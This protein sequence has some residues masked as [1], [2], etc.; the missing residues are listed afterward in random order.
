[1]RP[2]LKNAFFD[3]LAHYWKQGCSVL[4]FLVFTMGSGY[5]QTLSIADVNGNEDDG[6]ITVSVTLDVEV[7]GGFTVEVSTADGTATLADN[8]YASIASQTLAFVGTAG[9]TQTFQV[10]PI[11]DSKVEGDETL[12]ISMAN[13]SVD[14]DVTAT[15][16]VTILNDDDPGFSI[17][18]TEGSTQTSENG[19]TDSFTVV[20]DNGPETAVIID[21][22]SGDVGEGTVAPAQLTF[23]PL[24]YN[25]PRTVTVSGVDDTLLDGP[26]TYDITVSVGATSNSQFTGLDPQN[27][28][29]EN[30]D[31][32][33]ASATISSA[34]PVAAELGLV[35]ASFTIALDMV[36]NTGSNFVVG[37]T[38]DGTAI[39]GTDYLALDGTAE[40]PNGQQEVTILVTPVNDDLTEDIEEVV[41]TLSPGPG[42]TIGSP[43]TVT[44]TIGSEDDV[45]P[46]GYGITITEDL[47]DSNNQGNIGYTITGIPFLTSYE[48]TISSSE[49]GTPIVVNGSTFL[50]STL[51]LSED[52]SSLPDGIITFTVVLTNILGTEG[53]PESAL[54]V[55]NTVA[56]SGY[57]VS[58]N[59]DPIHSGNMSLVG[60][61]ISNAE[62]GANY[63]YTFSDGGGTDVSNS[64]QITLASQQITGIDLSG[65][66]DGTIT[67]SVFLSNAN[68]NGPVETDTSLKGSCFAG[69]TA[70]DLDS[71][72]DTAFCGGFT[73]NLNLYVSGAVPLGTVMRWSTNSDTSV[74]GDY[75]VSSIVTAPGTYYGFFYDAGNDCA[76]PGLEIT[77]VQNNAPNTGTV[78]NVSACSNGSNGESF[79]DLDDRISGEDPGIWTLVSG[80]TG[81]TVSIGTGN[82]V[83]FNGQPLGNYEFA[84]TTTS[85]V[86]P[87]NQQSVSLTVTVVDCVDPCNGGNSAPPFDASEPRVF[88]DEIDVDLNNYLTDTSAPAGTVLIWSLNQDPLET[89]A[90]INSR[91]REPGRYY[92]FYY[93]ATNL[94]R[95]PLVIVDLLRNYTPVIIP[96]ST[97]GTEIC[98]AGSVTLEAVAEVR[99]NSNILLRW[100]DAP[101]GGNLLG[102]G[103]SY[104]TETLTQTTS[105]YVE[106]S[107]N[108]CAT[109][110]RFEV[111]VT[112]NETPSAGVPTDTFACNIAGL[113]GPNALDLDTTL[114]GA[115]AGTWALVTDPSNGSLTISGE[116]LVD[117]EGL[118]SGD[119]VFR[120]TTTGAEAPCTNTSVEV[121]VSVSDCMVDTDGDGLLDTE[122]LELGT[123]P[124][125]PDTD[126]DGLTDGEEVLG[127][128]DLSTPLVP[129]GPS[130]PLD[131][132]DPFLT[133]DC[134][135]E[136]IDL[137]IG[138]SVDREVVMLGDQVRFTIT[139]E[140]T[141]M[142]RVLDIVVSDLLGDGFDYVSNTPSV[143]TYDE[144]SGEWTI[145]ELGPEQTVSLEL[146]AVAVSGGTLENRASLVSSFPDDGLDANNS[147]QVSIRVNLSQCEDPGTLC[148]IFSP[149]GDGINDQ[150][151]LVGHQQFPQNS[152]EIFDRYGNRVFQMDG[153][154]SSWEGTGKNGELPKG[155]YFYILD[156]Q[157]DGTQ[158][159]KG[160]IQILRNN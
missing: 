50:A 99:G 35:S 142:D 101:T 97:Q 61:T 65:L 15:A 56:P 43:D 26:Q 13:P 143:G 57:G 94:C 90:F 39:N 71:G 128:D 129:V 86:A 42:Y 55:K 7:L 85:A 12:T 54:V 149:N 114:S 87:C 23:T 145:A 9:E 24:N 100:F 48:V 53:N 52:L 125:N 136:D 33:V 144:S 40:I 151:V 95:S 154:D 11:A 21:L 103:S 6:P 2:F 118:P 10:T 160:W 98:G 34:S 155:T 67:L 111:V 29:V 44:L 91:V 141:T 117:F 5:G 17:V 76:S 79:I 81:H 131:P 108:A 64:G 4:F 135:P 134:N 20:L 116:N 133:P 30:L 93:D 1:M 19:D 80:P 68:G 115:D 147:A 123:D 32:E 127:E 157:G 148:N 16:I 119:Y 150:L 72:V 78:T 109:A 104:V 82:G 106:A 58:I 14:V 126:G 75:L 158:V 120:Y 122:E 31:N 47:V 138:K 70:P 8:D 38:L 66:A 18:P 105:F 140:N 49:G 159:V 153:Y 156:L 37:Y 89:T 121:T 73:Q 22:V 110:T 63:Y 130:D 41:V 102:M 45:V 36:N 59:Q 83:E 88:C 60:F 113:G 51:N 25:S 46:G 77:L 137:A 62:V 132:C 139:V 96:E 107:A 74:V 27:V 124:T 152:L 69:G 146:V 3:S 28:T 84:Y 92:G 112:V